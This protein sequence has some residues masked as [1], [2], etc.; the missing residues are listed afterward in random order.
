[1]KACVMKERLSENVF[2]ILH[3]HDIEMHNPLEDLH[4]SQVSKAIVEEYL[5]LRLFR[6]GQDVTAKIKM[7]DL[8]ISQKLTKLILF[9]GL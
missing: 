8:G 6:Y 2:N 1:M 3:E 9:K 7:S 5:N 4:F